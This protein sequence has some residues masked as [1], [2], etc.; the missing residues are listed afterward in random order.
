MQILQ[1]LLDKLGF[2][3]GQVP[4]HHRACSY[5]PCLVNAE[6]LTPAHYNIKENGTGQDLVTL[7]R[8]GY[9]LRT[10]MR[11][12]EEVGLLSLGSLEPEGGILMVDFAGEGRGAR[13]VSGRTHTVGRVG[14][15]CPRQ[16]ANR[17]PPTSH[18]AIHGD[19]GEMVRG[20]S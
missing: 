13:T 6:R 11:Y 16:S 20:L 15:T 7:L 17:P 9:N 5:P 4:V 12:L 1:P 2:P 8:S 10:P 19:N 14:Q 3:E 18:L